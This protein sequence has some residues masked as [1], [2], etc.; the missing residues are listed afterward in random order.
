MS[1][2][3]TGCSHKLLTPKGMKLL[4]NT[5][6]KKIKD[7]NSE[8]VAHLEITKVILTHYNIAKNDPWKHLFLINNLV[9]Y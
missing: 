4:R 9:N 7:E 3:K 8:N 1:K 6:S 2:I 5:K